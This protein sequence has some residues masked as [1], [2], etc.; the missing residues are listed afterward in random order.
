[1]FLVLKWI[2]DLLKLVRERKA[3]GES[4]KDLKREKLKEQISIH[5][6]GGKQDNTTRTIPLMGNKGRIKPSKQT[7]MS[8]NSIPYRDL[9]FT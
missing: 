6:K 5:R 3:T 8:G 2:T 1:M 9:I 7:L 4:R